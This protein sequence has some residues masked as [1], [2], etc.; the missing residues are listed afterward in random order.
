MSNL[1]EFNFQET[2]H[3]FFKTI[4]QII[5]NEDLKTEKY[6]IFYL[7]LPNGQRAYSYIYYISEPAEKIAFYLDG[8]LFPLEP[9]F[10]ITLRLNPSKE[11]VIDI[12]EFVME[13]IHGKKISTYKRVE[14]MHLTG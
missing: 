5:M 10:Y 9:S 13:S 6:Y 12:R 2:S 3:P 7:E 11:N 4:L 8:A 1:F 14:K